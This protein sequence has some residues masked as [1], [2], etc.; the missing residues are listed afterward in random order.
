[1][2]QID[3]NSV[4]Q[5]IESFLKYPILPDSFYIGKEDRK[6]A[7][8]NPVID[9]YQDCM[10]IF[11]NA[12]NIVRTKPE[13]KHLIKLIENEQ[14]PEKK[15]EH[16]QFLDKYLDK[17]G[18]KNL[19]NGYLNDIKKKLRLYKK[20]YYLG[21]TQDSI[22]LVLENILFMSIYIYR[23]HIRDIWRGILIKGG[24][25]IV[26]KYR[27]VFSRA[28]YYYKPKK[29]QLNDLE[30]DNLGFDSSDMLEENK[31]VKIKLI[32]TKR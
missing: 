15:K 25:D 31:I 18:V 10:A 32:L 27:E 22:N 3:I 12:I 11:S 9:S 6:H 13:V 17:S 29:K 20:R 5:G 24:D 23:R 8:S 16:R 14:E 19:F 21:R 4:K 26:Q 7:K 1:M 28:P 2:S 30:L